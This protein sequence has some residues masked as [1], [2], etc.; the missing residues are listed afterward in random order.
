MNELL[1]LTIADLLGRHPETRAVF[2]AHG[3][4]AL[5]S[6]DGLRVLAPFLTL[7]T[8][9]RSRGI[10]PESFL[11]LLAEAAAADD[12][13]EAPGLADLRRSG[14]LTLL[15]LMPCG[16][17]V[18]FGRAVTGFL[19]E[20]RESGGPAITYAVEG[21]LNQELSYYPYVD[22]LETL[23]ELPDIIVSADFNAF[24][25]RRFYKRFVEPG[26]LVGY[27]RVDP[28]A[29]FA[30]AGL[31]D[32]CGEY[33]VLGVNPLVIV[34][35]LDKVEGRP[36]PRRWA[37]ILDPAWRGDIALR[38]SADFFCHA[39]LLPIHQ[40]HGAEGLL[41][42]APNVREGL[43]P[44]QMVKQIDGGGGGALYVMPEFFAH[45][46]KRRERIKI[47]WPSDGALASPVTL[48]VKRDKVEELRPVLDWLTGPELARAL[49]GARFPVPHAG[50][51][52][53][54]REAPLKWLGWDWLR[55][56]DIREVNAGIDRVFLPAVRGVLP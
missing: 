11:R 27:G 34:A 35:D 2:A 22:T 26:H 44:A 39:V 10:A 33:F 45:R 13:L 30:A 37:D 42:L 38:G 25:Y 50:V 43:H 19:E 6:E 40:E 32:P 48:Q 5:V 41:K 51:E 8:A 29:A 49:V 14:E 23:E 4:E 7:G 56:N 15:A 54:L 9:L 12:I 21:N 20:L 47:L 55:A 31:P 3:L 52:G 16:L 17:K 53:E 24:Y 1:E 28:C 18:P 46:V 36:L